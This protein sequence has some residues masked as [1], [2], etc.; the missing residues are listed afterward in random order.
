MPTP[1]PFT[2]QISGLGNALSASI[3][4]R[5]PYFPGVKSG[6]VMRACISA[7]SV[8]ALKPRPVPVS[9]TTATSGIVGGGQQRLGGGVV[10]GFVEGVERLGPVQREGAHPVV[11]VDLQRHG[12]SLTSRDAGRPHPLL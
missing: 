6:S 1:T 7:R 9:S 5:K 12:C 3:R 8:P 10:E 11:V 2:A 4:P